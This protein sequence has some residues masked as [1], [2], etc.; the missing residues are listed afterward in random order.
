MNSPWLFGFFG[1]VSEGDGMILAI[2]M[3]SL[4]FSKE[5]DEDEG[6]RR[7]RR[8][9]GGRGRRTVIGVAGLASEQEM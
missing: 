4:G 9:E 5:M 6:R 8:K 1:A 3:N 7:R 2:V